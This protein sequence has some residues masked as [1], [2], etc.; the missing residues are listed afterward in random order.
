M[1]ACAQDGRSKIVQIGVPRPERVLEIE[2]PAVQNGTFR[3]WLLELRPGGLET[4]NEFL[5]RCRRGTGMAFV[6]VQHLDPSHHSILAGDHC[7]I[8]RDAGRRGQVGRTNKAGLRVCDSA[9]RFHLSLRKHVYPDPWSEGPSRRLSGDQFLHALAGESQGAGAIGIVFSG[10]GTGGTWASKTSRR[11]AASP[12][13]RSLPTARYDGMPRGA[14]ANGCV[15]FVCTPKG[16]ANEIER[17]RRHPYLLANKETDTRPG[18]KDDL[19]DAAAQKPARTMI[20]RRP[21]KPYTK[22]SKVDLILSDSA[23]IYIVVRC[24]AS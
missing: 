5:G 15:V 8:H 2:T 18:Q 21:R 19:E 14:V 23:P 4:Y 12:S 7:E 20:Q 17:I 16:I 22:S 9:E 24:D 10:T 6:V 13:P 11:R 1:F 3:L